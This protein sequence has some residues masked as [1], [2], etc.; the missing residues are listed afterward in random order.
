LFKSGYSGSVGENI[1][2]ED[3]NNYFSELMA[4]RATSDDEFADIVNQ[5]DADSVQNTTF[6]SLDAP[7]SDDEILRAI[8]KLGSNKA[9]STDNVLYKYFKVSVP[10]II[11]PLNMFLQPH[12]DFKVLPPFLVDWCLYLFIKREVNQIRINTGMIT[13]T[14]CFAKL[15][16]VIFNERLKSRAKENDIM[17]DAQFGFKNNFSTVDPVFVLNSLIQRQL[18]N[19]KKLYSCFIDYKN[20]YD[21]IERRRLWYKLIELGVD[22]K[23]LSLVRSMYSKIKLCVRHLGSLSDFFSSEIGLFQ[24][25][26]TS[27]KPL[28][29]IAYTRKQQYIVVFRL[30]LQIK[31]VKVNIYN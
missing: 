25:D 3:F 31:N 8:K 19:K 9:A 14:S 22:G 16:S 27:G 12:I 1:S 23:F 2:N 4:V 20:A 7:I 24:G 28:G 30:T 10:V 29:S 15:F 5:C 11:N 21:C 18:Q 17:S 26:I 6:D 13:L